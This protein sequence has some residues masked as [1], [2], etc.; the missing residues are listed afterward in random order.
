MGNLLKFICREQLCVMRALSICV[1][2]QTS[3]SYRKEK[4]R[5][6]RL[7]TQSDSDIWQVYGGHIC[8]LMQGE[9]VKNTDVQVRDSVFS[10]TYCNTTIAQSPADPLSC[11]TH[12]EASAP[13]FPCTAERERQFTLGEAY[14]LKPKA[15]QS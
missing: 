4:C 8:E 14:T 6:L 15:L 9:S 2:A 7:T 1:K 12:A 3:K 11:D 10:A 5:L 13:C